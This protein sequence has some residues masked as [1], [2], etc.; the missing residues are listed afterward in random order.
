V[1]AVFILG[2]PRSGTSVF[3]KT[4]A[5]HPDVATTTNL[6]RR[7]MARF[8][9]VRVA[10]LFGGRHRPVEAG[11]LWKSFWPDG[12]RL[13][14]EA[15]LTDEQRRFLEH[16]VA[17]HL[18]H[19]RKKVFLSKKPGLSMRVRWLAAA[20]PQARFIQM[21]RDGRATAASIL[22]QCRRFDVHWSAKRLWP[23][24]LEM[25]YATFSGALWNRL[26]VSGDETLKK[27]D[28]ARVLTIRYEELVERPREV[29]RSAAS[30]CGLPW[31]AGM[32]ALIPEL[33]NRNG[34][35]DGEISAEDRQRM[36]GQ[37]KPGL[38]YFGYA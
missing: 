8:W 34:R 17:G 9:L 29:F 33:S 32:D 24:L 13:A 15:D 27:L 5:Q 14:T 30:F 19:F 23:D 18:R 26:A 25:D 3:Y 7:F 31:T 20:L 35:W 16:I 36:L 38:E 2:C 22:R 37:V 4:L 1:T 12:D 21:V 28:P 6:T 10:E 11:K